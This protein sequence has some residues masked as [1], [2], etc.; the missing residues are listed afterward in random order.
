MSNSTPGFDPHDPQFLAAI[1][2]G[3]SIFLFVTLAHASVCVV[4]CCGKRRRPARVGVPPD[5]AR[6]ANPSPE[7]DGRASVNADESVPLIEA[8]GEDQPN[9]W[10][11]RPPDQYRWA[12][13]LFLAWNIPLI[14]AGYHLPLTNDLIPPLREKFRSVVVEEQIEELWAAERSTAKPSLTR[15]MWLLLRTQAVVGWLV[16]ILSGALSTVGRPLILREIVN[17]VSQT[18]TDKEVPLDRAV[19]LLVTLATVV[20]FEGWLGTL[21]RHLLADDLGTSFTSAIFSLLLKKVVQISD[22]SRADEKA[23]DPSNLTGNDLMRRFRDFLV[24]SNLP[25]AIA[26]FSGGIG[27]LIYVIDPVPAAAG[28]ATMVAVMTTNFYLSSVAGRQEK[29]NLERAGDRVG[30]LTE[31]VQSIKAVKF[32]GWESSYLTKIGDARAK[33]CV[34][35][36]RFRM[37]QVGSIALGRAS[38]ALASCAAISVFV[39][40]GNE[41][42]AGDIF[43]AIS[44]FASLRLSLITVPHSLIAMATISTSLGR[45]QRFLLGP[46]HP[47]RA[48]SVTCGDALEINC[49]TVLL[50]SVDNRAKKEAAEVSVSAITH[51]HTNGLLSDDAAKAM[52]DEVRASVDPAILR[53][54]SV[55]I[56]PGAIVAV[57]GSVGSGKSTL[58]SAAIG[59]LELKAGSVTYGSIGYAP[60]SAIIVSGTIRENIVFGRRWNADAWDAAIFGASFEHDLECLVDGAETL[61]GERGTTLSGGQQQRVS[62]ARALYG[63]PD[64]LVLDDPLSAV[65]PEVCDAIFNRAVVGTARRGGGVL[66]ACNQVH[67]FARCNLIVLLEKGAV[68]EQGAYPEL[69]QSGGAFSN[70]VREHAVQHSNESTGISLTDKDDGVSNLVDGCP[71]IRENHGN[72]IQDD[73]MPED[74]KAAYNQKIG[75]SEVIASGEIKQSVYSSYVRSMGILRFIMTVGAVWCGYAIMAFMDVWLTIWI[76]T[77]DE[78]PQMVSTICSTYV[79]GTNTANKCFVGIFIASSLTFALLVLAGSVSFCVCGFYASSTIHKVVIERLLYAPYAWFQETPLGRITSRF[80]ADLSAVDLELSFWLDNGTQL[81]SQFLAMIAVL[82]YFVW[83]VAFPITLALL[84]YAFVAGVVNRTNREIKREANSAMGPV[85]SNI[86]EAMR[87]RAL[88]RVMGCE[89]FFIERHRRFTDDFNRA[90]FASYALISWQQL[91]GALMAFIISIS[92][93]LLVVL[94]ADELSPSQ[95]GL[96]LSYSFAL[97]YFM[98]FLAMISTTLRSWFTSLERLQEFEVLPQEPAHYLSTDA[99]LGKWPDAGAI[100]FVNS[101]LRY[102]PGLPRA[103]KCINLIVDA[104]SKVGVVGRTGA[105]KSSL[106]SLLFRLVESTEGEVRIDGVDTSTVGLAALRQGISIIPQEPILMEGTVRYN[107][108]PFGRKSIEEIEAALRLSHLETKIADEDV[109]DGGSTLSA[110]QRQLVCFARALLH[111]APVVVMDEPTANCDMATDAL[112]QTMVREEFANSTVITIAHRLNTVIDSDKVLVLGD[113]QVLEYGRPSELLGNTDSHFSKMVDAT[114]S[115]S[116][117]ALRAKATSMIPIRD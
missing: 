64:L 8:S 44:V 12:S 1:S 51:L 2:V 66:M 73:G 91:F 103:L 35:I 47:P 39:L 54:L 28:I 27:T 65:D 107:L 5:D 42:N 67:L 30:I 25:T 57:V 31:I 72:V 116:A 53:G 111:R 71:A 62:I 36:K 58:I 15:A 96:V 63:R 97:P 76:D 10:G 90:N 20:L 92:A 112:I 94:G 21:Y 109:F 9:Q 89:E 84:A 22:Q 79:S 60:Q 99:S 48:V 104:G 85:Q 11:L 13:R 106:M 40:T 93:A 110:G 37:L 88:A 29:E 17:T 45:L 49:A 117:A 78:T 74:E 26:A 108:D 50:P 81:S 95:A 7:R 38:P 82:L 98:A 105:G 77:A 23:L 83:Q 87:S 6:P 32:F 59:E 16:A 56:S 68:V 100:E 102:A 114:G 115:A 19:F 24:A 43:A 75:R 14:L 33:E 69:L 61:V 101:A 18:G 46:E 3:G 52:R 4:C 86:S 80:T 34:G 41:L 70:L 55:T 113:G